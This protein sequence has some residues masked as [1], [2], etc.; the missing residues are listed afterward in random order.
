MRA[1]VYSDYGPPDVLRVQEVDKP[2]PGRGEVLVRVRATT[3]TAVDTFYRGGVPRLARLDAGLL[4]P[5]RAILGT[6]LAGVVE[7]VGEGV[8]RFAEGDAVYGSTGGVSGAHAEYVLLPGDAALTAKPAGLTFEQAAAVPY[9]ALTALHFLR[10]AAMV[11]RGQRVLVNGASGSVGSYAVQ[12][13]KHFGAHVTG[14][15][16]GAKVELVRSLGADRVIDY[17]QED[18]VRSGESYDVV[19]D[20]VGKRSFWNCRGSLTATGIYLTTIPTLPIL[21]RMLWPLKIGGKRARVA[22]AGMRPSADRAN[23]LTFL[24]GLLEADGIVPVV[25][26]SFPLERTAEA[27]RYVEAG[28][29]GGNVVITAHP[30][31]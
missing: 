21:L 12:L 10:D 22:F 17:T 6:E 15:C 27:H 19:F 18:F 30:T 4:R 2:V 31:P 16:S 13:A 5:K 23:D 11:R 26:R 9:G 7:A 28:H 25:D 14:V 3:V 1:I 24:G 29:K 20:V 8:E